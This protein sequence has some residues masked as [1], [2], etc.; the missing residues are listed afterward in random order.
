MG[1]PAGGPYGR[2]A[3]RTACKTESA[4]N[5]GENQLEDGPRAFHVAA[6]QAS[7]GRADAVSE[8]TYSPTLNCLV[9][10]RRCRSL[11]ST[12]PRTSA[13]FRVVRHFLNHSDMLA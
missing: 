11:F 2:T 1:R 6:L 3:P 12:F 8:Y 4:F 10:V 7:Q 13:R 5:Q 9:G